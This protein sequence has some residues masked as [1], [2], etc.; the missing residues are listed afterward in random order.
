MHGP[1]KT[2]S[3]GSI[4]AV[5]FT[6]KSI[7]VTIRTLVSTKQVDQSLQE[8]LLSVRLQF[9]DYTD[10]RDPKM[11]E[12]EP[13]VGHPAVCLTTKIVVLKT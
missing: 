1:N 4:S 11:G 9:E 5:R 6:W 12:S 13:T 8:I 2:H 10:Q 7:K 3:S